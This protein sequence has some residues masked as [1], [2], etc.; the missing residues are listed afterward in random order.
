MVVDLT[1]DSDSEDEDQNAMVAPAEGT[2]EFVDYNGQAGYGH[3]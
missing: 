2:V 3:C 1:A